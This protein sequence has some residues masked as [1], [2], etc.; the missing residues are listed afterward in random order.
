MVAVLPVVAG[1]LG[2]V[3]PKLYNYNESFGFLYIVYDDIKP[4]AVN[5]MKSHEYMEEDEYLITYFS[6]SSGATVRS[7]SMPC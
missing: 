1:A 4:I 7:C 2:T 5:P 6:T 3:S